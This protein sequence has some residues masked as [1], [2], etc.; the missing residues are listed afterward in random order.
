MQSLEGHTEYQSRWRQVRGPPGALLRSL[1]EDLEVLLLARHILFIA[2]C[3]NGKNIGL[4]VFP[5]V[6]IRY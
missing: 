1:L 5:H 6:L 3:G 4:T 2:M